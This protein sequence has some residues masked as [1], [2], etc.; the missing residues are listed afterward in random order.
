MGDNK[1]SEDESFNIG[2]SRLSYNSETGEV[3]QDLFWE[4][5]NAESGDV[6]AMC[7]LGN[8]YLSGSDLE[9]NPQKA[10]Y[11]FTKAAEEGESVAMFNLGLMYA[12]GFG[13]E[14][15]FEKA[16]AWM[17]RAQ[18]AG[19]DDAARLVNQFEQD[20]RIMCSAEEGN[21]KD[22]AMLAVVLENMASSNMLSIAGND[23]DYSDCLYWARKAARAGEPIAMNVLGVLY[24]KGQGTA[25]NTKEAFRW[26]LQAAER[27]LDIAMANTAYF[28]L[29]GKGVE[30]NP[31]KSAEWFEKA[32]SN[33]WNDSNQDLP[34]AR[35]IAALIR[36]AESGDVKAQAR[37]ADTLQEIG[38]FLE[39][40]GDVPQNA[41]MGSLRWAKKAAEAGD[42]TGI[43][44][45]ATAWLFGR[46]V[47]KNPEKG[48]MLLQQGCNLDDTDC[49]IKLAE[50]YFNGNGVERDPDHAHD[51]LTR[52][53]ELGSKNAEEILDR[54]SGKGLNREEQLIVT[55]HAVVSALLSGKTT[56]EVSR[57][58]GLNES[59]VVLINAVRLL[60]ELKRQ[61]E[62]IDEILDLPTKMIVTLILSK[63]DKGERPDQIAAELS[64]QERLIHDIDCFDSIIRK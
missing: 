12:K 32:V 39:S 44:V 58:F 24:S 38:I 6:V 46:G 47:E 15:D 17:R 25:K 3:K 30:L 53:K 23:Q 8:A 62:N 51:L 9:K 31:E 5:Q 50:A 63:L 42:A 28:Y 49:M 29:Y 27:G 14:R 37:L 18:A 34:R 19:D 13:V 59:I 4:K 54:I 21:S 33:G 41:Y 7:N 43:C 1:N 36:E 35:G 40:K 16:A 11:W 20:A 55:V 64:V 56:T 52:A 22:Q 57:D 2:I 10:I 60:R 45:L 61:D 26:Y 48:V